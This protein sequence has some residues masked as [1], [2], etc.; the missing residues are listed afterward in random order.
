MATV[1]LVVDMVRGFADEVIPKEVEGQPVAKRGRIPG[2]I[3][4]PRLQRA[5]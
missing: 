1:V 4:N 2:V 3:A 5:I